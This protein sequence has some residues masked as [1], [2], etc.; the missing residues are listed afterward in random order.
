MPVPYTEQLRSTLT[1]AAA[2]TLMIYQCHMWLVGVKKLEMRRLDTATLVPTQPASELPLSCFGALTNG[3]CM[4]LP[5]YVI[6]I[7]MHQNPFTQDKV[8]NCK[9]GCSVQA[10]LS[11][12]VS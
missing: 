9:S 10:S 2:K 5:E 4:Q 7:S 3:R 1:S 12:K 6:I 8:T 11:S